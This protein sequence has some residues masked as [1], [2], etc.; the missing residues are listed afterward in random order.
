MEGKEEEGLLLEKRKGGR[1][2]RSQEGGG[3]GEG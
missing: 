2:E 1:P 3:K